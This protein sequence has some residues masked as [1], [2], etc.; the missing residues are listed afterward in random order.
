MY[1]KPSVVTA[2]LN[3]MLFPKFTKISGVENSVVLQ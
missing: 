1:E 2:L 3:H